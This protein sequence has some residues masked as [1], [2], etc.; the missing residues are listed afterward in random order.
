MNANVNGMSNE[1]LRALL[2]KMEAELAAAKE[3]SAV[4]MRIT[5]G[6]KGTVCVH[7][8]GSKYGV[9]LYQESWGKL[10]EFMP[11]VQE[12]IAT[13]KGKLA[14]KGVEYKAPEQAAK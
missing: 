12:F 5:I 7:G 3:A 8:I 4:A 6:P 11:K 10:A 14:V 1:Q 9:A 2:V 13:N